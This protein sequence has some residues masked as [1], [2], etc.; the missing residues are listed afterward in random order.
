M[1]FDRSYIFTPDE[2]RRT[3]VKYKAGWVGTVR[4]QCADKAV[5]AGAAVLLDPPQVSE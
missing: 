2:D 1:R 4:R 3:S 5:A